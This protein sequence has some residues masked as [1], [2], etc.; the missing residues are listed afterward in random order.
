[1][2]QQLRSH[3]ER[4]DFEGHD[5]DDIF[6][7]NATHTKDPPWDNTVSS[8][9]AKP[10]ATHFQ[11]SHWDNRVAAQ[12]FKPNAKFINVSEN[13]KFHFPYTF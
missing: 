10:N 8:K 1:M 2:S 9:H 3:Q 5:I 11:S 6:V 4:E 12:H 13:Q 7:T